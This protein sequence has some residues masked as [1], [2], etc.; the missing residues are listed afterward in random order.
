MNEGVMRSEMK[1]T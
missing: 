1:G